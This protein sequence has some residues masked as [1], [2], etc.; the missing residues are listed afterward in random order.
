MNLYDTLSCTL[1]VNN[2]IRPTYLNAFSLICL[3]KGDSRRLNFLVR[4]SSSSSVS[5]GGCRN[6]AYETV[7]NNTYGY[8][9]D[10]IH[11]CHY[12]LFSIIITYTMR[13]MCKHRRRRL[14]ARYTNVWP[15]N[16]KPL[17]KLKLTVPSGDLERL[18]CTRNCRRR[19]LSWPQLVQV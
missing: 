13:L 14:I 3:V 15:S 19:L 9:L 2:K 6:S 16:G 1:H 12:F 18:R 11:A 17:P 8:R 5:I 4:L 10:R 7:A